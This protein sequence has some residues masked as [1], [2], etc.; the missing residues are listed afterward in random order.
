MEVLILLQI[1]PNN[2]NNMKRITTILFFVIV[3]NN[4]SNAQMKYD[5]CQY[6]H[7]FDGEWRYTNGSDTIRI[8]LRAQRDYYSII[9]STEDRIFGWH[10]YKQGNNVIESIYSNRFMTISNVDTITKRSFSIWLKMGN[11]TECS[12]TNKTAMGGIRD[13]L[14]GNEGKDVTVTLDATGTIMTW[15]Q[16]QEGVGVKSGIVGMTLPR[17][18]ILVKQ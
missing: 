17:Q 12:A 7:Q 10:E 2:Q 14:H 18:F 5:T 13:Y 1:V 8:Y 4:T 9:K 11:G 16:T 3:L 15:K 6:V